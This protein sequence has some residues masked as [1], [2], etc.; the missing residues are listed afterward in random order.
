[1]D[2]K[3]FHER[4]SEAMNEPGTRPPQACVNCSNLDTAKSTSGALVLSC[5]LERAITQIPGP[6]DSMPLAGPTAKWIQ[7]ALFTP[8]DELEDPT[9]RDNSPLALHR[10][11][12]ESNESCP[13]MLDLEG[14]L[15]NAP[16]DAVAKFH[17]PAPILAYGAL[18]VALGYDRPSS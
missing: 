16:N 17:P 18:R 13:I 9:G 2:L 15:P 14:W 4:V 3:R 12:E 7:H 8:A 6:L 5:L 11:A 10:R 1:M